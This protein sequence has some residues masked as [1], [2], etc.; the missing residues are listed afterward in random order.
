MTD[1]PHTT[2]RNVIRIAIPIV[3]V[4]AAGCLGDDDTEGTPT[5]EPTP[6]PTPEPTPTPT[7]EPPTGLAADASTWELYPSDPALWGRSDDPFD[8]TE[9][10]GRWLAEPFDDG[11]IRL[12]VENDEPPG[13]AG[14]RLPLGRIGEVGRIEVDSTTVTSDGG[15]D[16]FLGVAIYVD[17][18]G[19]GDFFE[20]EP[21]DGR[22][23][24]A[25]F[26]GDVEAI[27]GVPA[28][29]E[30]AVGLDTEMELVPPGETVVTVADLHAGWVEGVG[31]TT[32]T[33]VY[34]GLLGSGDGNVEEA[35]LHDVTVVPRGE[36]SLDERV[37]TWETYPSDAALWSRSGD[38][39]EIDTD[40]GR[41]LAEPGP[42]GGVRCLVEGDDPPG[43]AGCRVALGRLGE[44]ESVAIDTTAV[45]GVD[46][47][48]PLVGFA[49]YLDAAGDG[50]YFA[51]E[52]A[53][54][55]ER[56]VDFDGD[57]ETLGGFPAGEPFL[58]DGTTEMEL[59][60][61]GGEMVTLADLQSGEVEGVGGETPAG[62][63][64][65]VL[66][67]GAGTT[68]E[69]IVDDIEIEHVE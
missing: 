3:A 49:I 38:P 6:T 39:I 51:Y 64:V 66:G 45:A 17:V 52:P 65:G 10:D 28:G 56:F 57:V 18:D 62:L 26:G 40:A 54:G 58:L 55:R 41:W 4:P 69:A 12:R 23:A 19:D 48:P 59:V 46:G 31:A 47:E 53:D 11:D 2:R 9:G 20:Y 16:Q 37:G 63:Y 27:A 33:A 34:V 50:D 13:N 29:T 21:D 35:T 42:D 68:T 5:A 1:S 25:D 15:G 60:P 67:G 22:E 44:V 30:A 7:P 8:V 36:L 32:E 24:F 14:I 61:P 43:N